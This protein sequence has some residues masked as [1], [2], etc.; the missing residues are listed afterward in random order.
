MAREEMPEG[1]IPVGDPYVGGDGVSRYGGYT[2]PMTAEENANEAMSFLKYWHAYRQQAGGPYNPV[3]FGDQEKLASVPLSDIKVL[4]LK[5][6]PGARGVSDKSMRM[7][8]GEYRLYRGDVVD[9]VDSEKP[10]V[11]LFERKI[12]A[13][14]EPRQALEYLAAKALIIKG[15]LDNELTEDVRQLLLEHLKGGR[16]LT[17]T[18]MDLREL[19]EPW[20][21]DP[22]K[23][24]P[25]GQIGIGFPPGEKAPENVLMAYRLENMIRTPMIEA[26]N[27]GRLAIGDATNDYV[28]GYQYSAILDERTTDICREND[29][30][31]IRADDPRLRKLTPPVHY[32]CRSL[33]VY[34]TIDDL[35][36]EFSSDEEL[37]AAVD[38]IQE[39]FS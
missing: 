18:I 1:A 37:D 36:V 2:R 24:A 20:I 17:E 14:F 16:T 11:K 33:L 21:G 3:L 32:Q 39:G 6:K 7:A 8:E 22:T 10:S 38:R 4:R 19:F 31:I 35:P 26:Y 29:G 15:L 23:L 28:V 30:L 13:G 25:S 27:Q 34:V 9:I 5:P 12:Y